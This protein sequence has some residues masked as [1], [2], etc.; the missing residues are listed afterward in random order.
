[1]GGAL[2]DSHGC[3]VFGINLHTFKNLGLECA[4]LTLRDVGTAAGFA[5]VLDHTADTQRTVQL[6][7]DI[8]SQ[9]AVLEQLG[10]G[11]LDAERSLEEI[12]HL[13]ELFVGIVSGLQLLEIGENLLLHGNEHAAENLFVLDRDRFEFVGHHVVDVFH[14]DNVGILFVEVLNERSVTARTEHKLSVVITERSI[15]EIGGQ[16]VG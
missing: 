10:V 15:V 4:V 6:G 14:K 13:D 7:P 12:E 3:R 11:I 16:G 8:N 2:H 5:F 9:L 1:M